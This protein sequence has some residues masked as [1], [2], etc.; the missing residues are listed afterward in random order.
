MVSAGLVPL[1]FALTGPV[2]SV[3]GPRGTLLWA[4]VV[5]G[6]VILLTMVVLPGVLEPQ[7]LIAPDGR[8]LADA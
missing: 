5:G 2:S 6:A 8:R 1:S 3:L 4:G 7:R